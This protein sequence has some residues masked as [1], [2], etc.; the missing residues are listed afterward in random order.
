MLKR[1]IKEADAVVGEDLPAKIQVEKLNAKNTKKVQNNV[2]ESSNKGDKDDDWGNVDWPAENSEISEF[3]G[4][5][6]SDPFESNDR[7]KSR[8][9]S[10][11]RD[12]P[13]SHVGVS[14]NDWDSD[15]ESV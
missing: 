14:F 5:P 15:F 4:F 2:T 10:V 3:T 1:K 9:S 7:R 12:S 6:S 8:S 13:S 11:D